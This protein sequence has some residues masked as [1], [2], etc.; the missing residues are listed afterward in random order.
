M[1][2]E[3]K[4]LNFSYSKKEVLKNINLKFPKGSIT[5]ILGP[6]GIGKSTLLKLISGKEKPIVGEVLIDG[7]NVLSI[8]KKDLAKKI[9]YIGQLNSSTFEFL[10]LDVVLMGRTS[11]MGY[12]GT[13]K[14]K[15]KEI[16]L[17]YL[18]EMNILHLKDK[19]YNH[20]SGGE[21]QLVLITAA[22]CQESEFIILDE[23][24]S[25]LDFGKG[26]KFIEKLKDLSA[27][28][29]KGIIFTTHYPDHVLQVGGNCVILSDKNIEVS[30]NTQDVLNDEILSKIYNIPIRKV[31]LGYTETC[32]VVE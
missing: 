9:A 26:Y 18:G 4:N 6:N 17:K 2:I 5:S 32:V 15:D 23:P 28:R 10:V 13:P 8:K 1:T 29:K 19:Y 11:S 30:G 25:H 12:F 27:E 7:I 14:I 16:A 21:Q 31:N 20:L 22:L 24:T 3:I